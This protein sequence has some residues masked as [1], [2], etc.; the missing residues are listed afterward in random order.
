MGPLPYSPLSEVVNTWMDRA[1]LAE[2]R[3]IAR[4]I[5][6]ESKGRKP[7]K[8]IAAELGVPEGTL[9]S[10]KQRDRWGK[11]EKLQDYATQ[12]INRRHAQVNRKAAEAIGKNKELTD[13]EKDFCAAAVATPNPTQAAMMT[14]RYKTYNCAK[15]MAWEFMQNPAV[16]KEIERLKAIKRATLLMD[17]DDIIDMHMRIA[18]ADMTAFVEW[19]RE[20]VP[21]MGAF[22]PV[23][24]DDP[25]TG[26]R[27]TL[28][29]IVNTVR[30]R[31]QDQV[32]GAVVAE[33]KQGKNG[34]SVKLADRQRSLAFLE[35]FFEMNP[36]D[37]HRKEYDKKR[38]ALDERGIKVQEDKLNGITA[39][40]DEIKAGLKG[41]L[42]VI[43]APVPN[44]SIDDE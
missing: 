1:E 38:L 35:R 28:K 11:Y 18:F 20:E 6:D 19:G 29:K 12:R 43:N 37:R 22:G 42:D 2:K 44:R 40:V 25:V 9:R 21:V 16:R 41:I 24:V 33:I 10:W 27:I 5:Y 13:I 32:D 31:E 36:M 15:S 26:K 8:E 3:Q 17:A 23:Q 34:A 30:F 39:D 7:L 4:E 14:G